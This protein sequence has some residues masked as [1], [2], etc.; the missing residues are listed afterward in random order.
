[1]GWLDGWT[2]YPVNDKKAADPPGPELHK[3]DDQNI[4]E[5]F[6]DFLDVHQDRPTGPSATSRS[7]TARRP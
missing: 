7:A 1:M 4:R 5:L 3:P 6:A 2:F